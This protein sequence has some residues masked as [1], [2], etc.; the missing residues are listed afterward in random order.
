MLN[1]LVISRIEDKVESLV[2]NNIET[3]FDQ[4]WMRNQ[5]LEK[6]GTK[7]RRRWQT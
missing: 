4:P 5:K 3:T 6:Y 7:F 1:N 2:N